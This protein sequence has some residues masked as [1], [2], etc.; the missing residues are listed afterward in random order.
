M[1]WTRRE[2]LIRLGI[3]SA[4]V[5]LLSACGPAASPPAA[6]PTTAPAPAAKAPAAAAPTS[7]PAQK[8]PAAAPGAGKA[9][10]GAWPFDM[11]PAGHFNQY[12]P[13]GILGG[14][15]SPA[16][17]IYWDLHQSPL[18]MYLWADS[19]WQGLLA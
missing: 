18:G 9:F 6:G 1:P 14:P 8:A 4:G 19:K 13:R 7:A 3:G 16:G 17:S 15:I 10:N 12:I 5:A 2:L 11:P